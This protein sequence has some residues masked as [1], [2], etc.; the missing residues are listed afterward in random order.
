L[1]V[2]SHSRP[3]GTVLGKFSLNLKESRTENPVFEDLARVTK[4]LLPKVHARPL[5]L[6]NLNDEFYFPRGNEQLSS[7]VLQVTRG[8][9]LLMDETGL[10]EGTLVEKGKKPFTRHHIDQQNTSLMII[11]TANIY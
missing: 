6:K 11:T 2:A 8:T 7:G 1:L 5:T 4:N 9:A 10:E 3:S